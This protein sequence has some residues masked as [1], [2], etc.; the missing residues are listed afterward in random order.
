MVL[1]IPV[2]FTAYIAVVVVLPA[3]WQAVVPDVVR[4]VL[5]LL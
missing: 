3:V 1:A 5:H 2:L 4:S